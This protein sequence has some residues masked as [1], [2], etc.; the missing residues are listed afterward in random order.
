MKHAGMLLPI[1]SLP[2]KYGIGSLG[3]AAFE[4]IDLLSETGNRIWQ[5]LPLGPTGF[6]D[7][8]YQ[9]FSAFAGNP[10]FIDLETLIEEG[11]LSEEELKDLDFGEDK[12]A[13]DYGRLYNAKLTALDMAYKAWLKKGHSAEEAISLLD[14]ECRSYCCFMAIKDSMN[15]ASWDCWPD[16]LRDREER[17]I[18]AFEEE[19][20]SEIGS[21]A[22]QQLKFIE[23]W[24]KLRAYAAERDVHI[25]G[26]IPIYCAPDSADVWAHR[27]LF[28]YDALAHPKSVAGVPPDAFSATGQLWGNPLYD[29]EA[30]EKSGFEWWIKRMDYCLKLYDELRVDHFRGFEAY[31]SIPWGDKTAENGKWVKG[32]GMALFEA[33]YSHFGGKKLPII[34]ED[35]GVITPEVEALMEETGFPGMKVLQFA[36]DSGSGNTYLPH[37]FEGKN[38]IC[39]TGTHDNDTLRHW[40]DTLPDWQREYIYQYTSRS[41]NDWRYMPELLI[42]LAMGSVAETV[43]VPV[44]DYLELQ[45]EARIN[46]PGRA[47]GN[48]QWRMLPEEFTEEKKRIISGILGTFGRYHRHQPSKNSDKDSSVQPAV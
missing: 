26:D 42:K 6:G 3:K 46:E 34:A 48:W 5:I 22:F 32:P 24:E 1:F 30:H 17:S 28:Q 43:V 18:S 40:F 11:L 36:W 31:Y 2:G 39:Y 21:Y 41:G 38:C 7:S 44:P 47:G 16:K 10:Y 20:R 23:Q 15:G 37:N 45:G 33:M 35:L 19:H 8:P 9:A 29:W 25:L 12:R 13:V 27:E 4:F 14:E